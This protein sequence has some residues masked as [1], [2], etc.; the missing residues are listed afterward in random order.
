MNEIVKD[1]KAQA[2]IIVADIEKDSKAS[3]RRVRKATLAIARL[4]REY[5]K[6]SVEMD[7]Q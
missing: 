5:R 1:L 4:G 7:K 3:R 6:K 2:E